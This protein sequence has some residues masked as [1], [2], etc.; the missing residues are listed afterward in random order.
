MEIIK[1]I[2]NS[3]SKSNLILKKKNLEFMKKSIR[4]CLT[5]GKRW[6]E[7]RFITYDL[8]AFTICSMSL[9]VFAKSSMS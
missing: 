9:S 2:F 4:A 8:K 7:F 5:F 1:I 3:S 6:L